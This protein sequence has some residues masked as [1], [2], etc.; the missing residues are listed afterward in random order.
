MSRCIFCGY[1]ELACP[2]DAITLGNEFEISEYSRDDLIYTKDMLLA[3][4]IKRVPVR[5]PTSSTRPIPAYKTVVLMSNFLVWVI[6]LV[7]ALACSRTG[8]AVISFTN[9]F[10]SALALIGNL[11]SLAVLFLLASAEFV[12]AAQVLVYAGAVMVM[13]LF[14][15]AYLGGRADAPW[16]GGPR[17]L[18]LGAFVVG[19]RAPRRGDRR[20]RAE[21]ER[22][23][24]R[25]RGD[26]ALVREPGRRSASCS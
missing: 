2:F 25:Q 17:W 9:P 1:C 26:R 23:P 20:P 14:V 19:G 8:V 5:T 6:W 24:L 16:A 21:G 3:E 15:V 18:Q 12:A 4:P 22:R 11:A 7:A 13:F 10:Y